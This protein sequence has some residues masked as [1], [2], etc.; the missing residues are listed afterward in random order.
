MACRPMGG[1]TLHGACGNAS[2]CMLQPFACIQLLV[3]YA[4][5]HIY[6]HRYNHTGA[7]DWPDMDDASPASEAHF[8]AWVAANFGA[9]P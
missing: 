9:R 3:L 6:T 8:K 4:H 1:C 2:C 7:Q 5:A